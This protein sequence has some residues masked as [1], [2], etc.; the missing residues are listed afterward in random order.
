MGCVGSDSA[1]ASSTNPASSPSTGVHEG[2]GAGSTGVPGPPSALARSAVFSLAGSSHANF[3]G[4]AGVGGG[5]EL[6]ALAGTE[7]TGGRPVAAL[8][9]DACGKNLPTRLPQIRCREDTPLCVLARLTC[10]RCGGPGGAAL[11]SSAAKHSAASAYSGLERKNAN[12][13][14]FSEAVPAQ[15]C[16]C[17]VQNVTVWPAACNACT[18]WVLA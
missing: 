3:T 12:A 15:S 18:H 4:G 6:P 11:A 5:R 2:A 9:G 13:A 14:S 10:A 1:A 8:P 7:G 16:L 17:S